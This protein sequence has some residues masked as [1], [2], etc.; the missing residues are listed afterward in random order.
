M[1]SGG[2]LANMRTGWVPTCQ[3]AVQENTNNR[4]EPRTARPRYT[5]I[6]PGDEG[7]GLCLSAELNY[8]KSCGGSA[9]VPLALCAWECQKYASVGFVI[10]SRRACASAGVCPCCLGLSAALCPELCT[11]AASALFSRLR[12]P[13]CSVA[14]VAPSSQR[15]GGHSSLN[16]RFSGTGLEVLYKQ[17]KNCGM[18]RKEVC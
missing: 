10:H 2:F 4:E 17:T 1:A 6:I 15:S 8:R 9:R 14:A 16:Q 13:P 12:L 3:Q 5:H 11:R 18:G 7:I